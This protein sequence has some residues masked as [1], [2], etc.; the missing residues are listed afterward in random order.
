MGKHEGRVQPPTIFLPNGLLPGEDASVGQELD[1]ERWSKAE[2]RTAELIACI[3]PNPSSEERRNAVADYV[4]R[5]IMKCFPCQ[6]F[7]FGSVPLKTYLPDGDIDLTAFRKN[8][9]M[10]DSWAHHVRDILEKEEKNENAE[11]RVKEVQYIQAE[12][13]IVKCLVENIVVD[14]SF[15]QLGGLCTLCFLEEVDN[16]INQEHLFKRSIILIKAWCYY[17]SRILGAHHGLISTYA[18]EIL[19]LYIFHV[20]NKKFVGPLEVLYRFLE[21]FSKFDWDNFCISLWGPVPL[22]SLPDM[23]AEPP[24]KDNGDFLLYKRFLDTRT[25]AY[26]I[27]PNGQENQGQT[28]LSKHFNVIDP[29]RLNN[30][31]G[32]SVNRGNFFRIRSAFAFG[33]KKL[34]QL[35]DCPKDRLLSEIDEFFTNTWDRHRSGYRSD[36]TRNDPSLSRLYNTEKLY[37]SEKLL[38]SSG[39]RKAEISCGHVSQ[40]EATHGSHVNLPSERM[41]RSTHTS[42]S[43]A[44]QKNHENLYSSRMD[45]PRG[46]RIS[47]QDYYPDRHQRRSRADDLVRDIQGRCLFARTQSSPELS[48]SYDEA[49]SL[50]RCNTVPE[51]GKNQSNSARLDGHR[52]KIMETGTVKA[53]APYLQTNGSTLAASMS[54]SDSYQEED[55]RLG[56]EAEEFTS[57]SG[58]QRMPQGQQVFMN[59]LAYPQA[60][61]FNDQVQLPA[62]L[63]S[64]HLP[65]NLFL[66]GYGQRNLA[67][68]VP[69][70]IPMIE[71]L[72]GTN[73]A[74]PHGF[75]APPLAHYFPS[76]GMVTTAENLL[77]NGDQHLNPGA[78]SNTSEVDNSSWH[79]QDQGSARGSVL[80][81]E[82]S[83]GLPDDHRRPSTASSNKFVPSSRIASFD[84]NQLL[85]RSAVGNQIINRDNH[86]DAF[87]QSSIENEAY[88]DDKFA[89]NLRPNQSSYSSS[90]RS[91]TS[92]EN[93]WDGS[94]AKASISSRANGG[95]RDTSAVSSTVCGKNKSMSE[96]PSAPIDDDSRNWNPALRGTEITNPGSQPVPSLRMTAQHPIAG[97]EPTRPG[98]LDS[99]APLGPVLLGPG[100]QQKPGDNSGLFFHPKG[101]PVH[102]MTMVPLYNFMNDTG[103]PEAPISLSNQEDG[104][105]HSDFGQNFDSS[106]RVN[107]PEG[108]NMSDRSSE[109]VAAAPAELSVPK[110]DILESDFTSHLRNLHYGWICQNARC[111]AP[112]VYHYP[113]YL[114]GRVPWDGNPARPVACNTGPFTQLMGCG[115]SNLVHFPFQPISMGPSSI[116][117]VD[118]MPGYGSGTG[119]YL[120]NPKVSAR[121][122]HSSISRR[123]NYK[124]YRSDNYSERESNR[125]VCPKSRTSS[126]RGYSRNQVVDKPT[127]RRERAT[128]ISSQLERTWSSSHGHNFLASPHSDNS[129]IYS[130]SIQGGPSNLS[131]YGTYPLTTM[132]SNTVSS[133][134][135]SF[136]PPVMFCT[137]DSNYGNGYTHPLSAGQLEFGSLGAVGFQ[138][139]NDISQSSGPSPEEQMLHGGSASSPDLP[140]SP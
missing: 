140:S 83:V 24:R 81:D 110:P 69:T 5:L 121:Q 86:S 117:H 129:H 134:G 16:L 2:E 17:E 11:F 42:L 132:D 60:Y 49:S 113:V 106:G 82:N 67:G 77:D 19:V 127:P 47:K 51:A 96:R 35:L 8:Q 98:L 131:Q 56:V 87:H 43:Q 116:Y 62:S 6:V 128:P 1:W 105:D 45:H 3:Q 38:S 78:G 53:D 102:F 100:S 58:A 41:A 12:V 114:Q 59:K 13:K 115:S 26:T 90:D 55:S 34:A 95:R 21:F 10:K 89:A 84:I 136:P 85:Q 135:P 9:N 76:V 88:L 54:A 36:A 37:V 7:T 107:Q 130:N 120:P 18:L 139:M 20:Y 46:D 70:N 40:A 39:S 29:L 108:I 109:H 72:W 103:S 31:L 15:D 138:R 91:M 44:R 97:F 63:S 33:T 99:V 133:N 64:S 65:L 30:N 23:T 32:R 111:T 4:Q 27:F 125:T 50:G 61:D 25:S 137:Y 75:V 28:F 104:L 80:D 71:S 94:S 66:M 101:P 93:S 22:S 68:M 48:D 118:E 73:M 57:V 124:F 122:R 119:T 79:G 123:P 74:F 14:I 52:K 92:S 126:G 112:P